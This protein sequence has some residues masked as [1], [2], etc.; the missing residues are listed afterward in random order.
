MFRTFLRVVLSVKESPH[1]L[2]LCQ[3]RSWQ[4]RPKNDVPPPILYNSSAIGVIHR[5]LVPSFVPWR[6]LST[7]I[8]RHESLRGRGKL[9]KANLAGNR[10]GYLKATRIRQLQMAVPIHQKNSGKLSSEQRLVFVNASSSWWI[11]STMKSTHWGSYLIF[12]SPVPWLAQE[13]H[14]FSF[15]YTLDR[16]YLLSTSR[17]TIQHRSQQSQSILHDGASE[18]AFSKMNLLQFGK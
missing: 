17:P 6:Q 4:Q 7:I 2:I 10:R 5:D 14:T 15:G 11:G 16:L 1:Q 13:N 3:Q 12:F 9:A 18:S 8:L